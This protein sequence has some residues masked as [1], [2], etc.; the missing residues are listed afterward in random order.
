MPAFQVKNPSTQNQKA[1]IHFLGGKDWHWHSKILTSPSMHRTVVEPFKTFIPL[2]RKSISAFSQGCHHISWQ[3][4]VPMWPALSK[5]HS[6]HALMGAGPSTIQPESVTAIVSGWIQMSRLWWCSSSNSSIE[7]LCTG[8]PLAG[9]YIR[10]LHQCQQGLHLTAYSF[11]Q[12]KSKI[13][14][15]WTSLVCWI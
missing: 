10:C 9:V 1:V 6:F 7:V 2:S 13:C 8:N 12:N 11:V 5:T 14:F 4:S 15:I 3:H